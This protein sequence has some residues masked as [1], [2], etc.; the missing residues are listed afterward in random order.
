MVDS[1]AALKQQEAE[2]AADALGQSQAAA[3]A[4]HADGL[5]TCRAQHLAELE[6]QS[7]QHAA[8]LMGLRQQLAAAASASDV[9]RE[10][11]TRYRAQKAGEVAELDRR[12]RIAMQQT[13]MG[14]MLSDREGPQVTGTLPLGGKRL[15][16]QVRRCV[17]S[18]GGKHMRAAKP[19]RRQLPRSTAAKLEGSSQPQRVKAPEPVPPA[20]MTELATDGTAQ[21]ILAAME[22]DAIAAM[23]REAELERVQR[24]AAEAALAQATA[25]ADT[26]HE[27]VRNL[28]RELA[29]SKGR[30]A[31]AEA[32]ASAARSRESSARQLISQL[33]VPAR[34]ARQCS[35]TAIWRLSYMA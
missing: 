17:Q 29:A 2:V 3:E 23:S 31:D 16:G 14:K 6:A 21:I 19:A 22:S 18:T 24:A 13:R 34:C 28:Q 25:A 33:Q 11:F 12:L 15:A 7:T 26:L 1:R 5:A 35:Q 30:A 8:D 4:A 20:A 10:Q 32:S 9:V 27:R